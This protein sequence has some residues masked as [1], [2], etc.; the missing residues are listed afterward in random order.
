MDDIVTPP[1]A[2]P[3]DLR[4][5]DLAKADRA[6]IERA[7]RNRVQTL[8]LG[9]GVMLAR[10][11]G[12]HKMFLHTN[13]RGFACHLAMDGYWEIWVTQF[14]ARTLKPGMVAV[15]VGA[16]YGYYTLLFGDAVTASGKV[17]AVEPNPRAAALLR[18][19]ILLNGMAGHVTAAQVA[20]GPP[21][22]SE[23][24]LFVPAGEPKNA[25]VAERDV[26]GA[27]ETMTVPVTTLDTIT[28][29]F[30]RVDMVKIDAEGAEI[31]IFAGMRDVIRK[32]HP[33]LVL[34]F[35]ASR[36]AD[37]SGF[38]DGLLAAYPLVFVVGYGGMAEPISREAVLTDRFG[39]DRMLYFPRDP[40]EL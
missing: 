21:G 17:L 11:L 7:I 16:N 36:Y 24:R 40:A 19:T 2:Y 14:F 3:P 29:D 33:S 27:G 8:Y 12:Q 31:G 37:P 13:D 4:P 22:S 15:D 9:D 25:R 28:G 23:G 1:D 6:T 32:H 34:E 5:P 20:L 35:N 30:S 26:F 18:E 38:L 39:E 10:V